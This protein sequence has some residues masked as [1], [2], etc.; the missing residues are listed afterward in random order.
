MPSSSHPTFPAIACVLTG[1][2]RFGG[3]LPL[4]QLA[5]V[6]AMAQAPA[7]QPLIACADFGPRFE[8]R[9]EARR[10]RCAHPGLAT[11]EAVSI[12]HV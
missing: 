2:G 1:R 5:P 8:P 11:F 3:L 9:G 7:H 4:C 6:N 10:D 12:R